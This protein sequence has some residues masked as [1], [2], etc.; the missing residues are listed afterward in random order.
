MPERRRRWFWLAL[1]VLVGLL[2][3]YVQRR[4][5]YR[6]HGNYV[7]SEDEVER[8]HTRLEVLNQE[9]AELDKRVDGLD[10]DPL[11]MEAAIRRSKNLVRQGETIYRVEL[12]EDRANTRTQT[13]P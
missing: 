3:A 11:E 6:L 9:E 4:D 13:A 10:S 7:E 1:V 8:L 12:P 2:A 5:L